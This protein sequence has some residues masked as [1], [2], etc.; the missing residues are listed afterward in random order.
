MHLIVPVGTSYFMEIAKLRALHL[1]V[2]QVFAAYGITPDLITPPIQATTSRWSETVYDPY[3]NMLRATT[4]T[5]AA[6]IG[7][8][9]TVTVRPFDAAYN[10]PSDF[11]SRIARNT[12]LVLQH[13]AYLHRVADPAAGSYY[14]EQLTDKLG[15]TAWTLLQEIERA[16]GLVAALRAGTV[17]G[18]IREVRERRLDDVSLRRRVLLGT[19]QYPNLDETRLDDVTDGSVPTPERGTSSSVA[20]DADAPLASL[21]HALA[22]GA[23]VADVVAALESGDA[24]SIDPLPPIR[25]AEAFERLRLATE[26]YAETRGR[27]PLVFLLPVG[28]PAWRS[29]RANFARNFFGCAGFAVQEHLGFDTPEEGAEAALDAE[30]DIVVVCSSDAEYPD[31]VPPACD[32]LQSENDAPLIVVAGSPDKLPAADLR[33][34][35]VDDFIHL[36]TPLLEALKTYQERLGI[37]G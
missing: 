28:K 34:A 18:Q 7:G 14:V 33:A 8:S 22:N 2:Q 32:R 13:E 9:T 35:G 12:P 10:A 25:G 17:Q 5:A 26:R 4:E 23:T 21:K 19:N 1:L 24:S 16:G 29:A 15:Q 11:S 37:H 27:P 20:I 31:V 3:V 30:A 6:V 36:G